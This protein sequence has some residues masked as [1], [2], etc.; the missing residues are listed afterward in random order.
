MVIYQCDVCLKEF[1][2][3]GH[4][5]RH[6][7]RKYPCNKKVFSIPLLGCPSQKWDENNNNFICTYCNKSYKHNF[8]LNR[9]LKTCKL[10]KKENIKQELY[11]LLVKQFE[12]Q[13]K[14][15]L[16][17]KQQISMLQGQYNNIN[18]ISFNNNINCN[19]KTI[20]I[21][22]YNKTDISHI[23]DKD[24]EC[25]MKR[26]NMSV[27]KLIEKTHYDPTRPENK[28]IYISN[29]KDK[30]IM[31]WNG[32]KWNLEN[33]DETLD[34]LY[35]NSSNI[36]EDKI[37]TWE[38]NKYQYNPIVV[39]KFYKFLDNKEKDEIKN[40]IKDEIK[41]ILYNNRINK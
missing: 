37:E 12:Q 20:N 33:R 39:N 41:L 11:D 24:F 7:N 17:L 9:H 23:S 21:I 8:H 22:A 29:I 38:A 1:T 14:E 15:N 19:N 6:K 32:I 18:K 27:P 16:F 25:I 34:E 35:E 13:K 31:T 40:K 2:Q 28:N 3:C 5:E 36:L 30:Y 4:Y 10:K 26:C